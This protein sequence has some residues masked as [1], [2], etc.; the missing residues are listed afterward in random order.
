VAAV[1][2]EGFSKEVSK[3]GL[4]GIKKQTSTYEGVGWEQH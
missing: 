2:R 1:V 4:I 3:A